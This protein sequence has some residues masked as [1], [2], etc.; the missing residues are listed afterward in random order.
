M[1]C[2]TEKMHP[3]FTTLPPPPADKTGWPWTEA[4]PPLPDTM[5]D[6]RPWP[7]ISLVTPSYNQGAF[8]EETIR[9]VLLQGYPNLE[10]FVIDGGSSDESPA[11]IRKYAPWLAGWLSEPDRGQS[12]AINKGLR[13]SSGLIFNWLNSDDLLPPGALA[14]V[15]RHW[16]PGRSHML[17]GRGWLVEA[18]TRRLIQDWVPVPP[19]QPLDLMDRSGSVMRMLQPSTFVARAW[20]CATGGIREDLHFRMDW[21]LQFRLSVLLRERLQIATT[22]ANLSITL[23][24][25]DTKTSRAWMCIRPETRR[26]LHDLYRHFTWSERLRLF[27]FMRNVDLHELVTRTRNSSPAPLCPLLRLLLRRPDLLSSRFYLG[28]VRQSLFQAQ[29]TEYVSGKY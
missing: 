27:P 12:H 24:H 13:R 29:Q 26:V 18:D 22:P 3:T 20:L 19:R 15:G 11:I 2:R 17:T 4:S 8:I 1:A 25:P 23:Y 10:Y 6:G 7:R 9:S 5:S 14:E 28:A 16:Q 21:E